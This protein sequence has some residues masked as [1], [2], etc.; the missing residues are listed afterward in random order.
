M[1]TPITQ[2]VDTSQIYPQPGNK[3]THYRNTYITTFWNATCI[4]YPHASSSWALMSFLPVFTYIPLAPCS[5][6][7]FLYFISYFSIYFTLFTHILIIFVSF[8]LCISSLCHFSFNILY[9]FA[10]TSLALS[11]Y[12]FHYYI[13]FK[14]LVYST[15]PW[16]QKHRKILFLEVNGVQNKTP[17]VGDRGRYGNPA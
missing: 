6:P 12:T 2:T 13:N 16:K 4:S 10:S 17:L 5:T 1:T 9:F 3:H 14:L 7:L 8:S 15:N 11:L